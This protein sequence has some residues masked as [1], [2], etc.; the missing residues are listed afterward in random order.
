MFRHIWEQA[1]PI[2]RQQRF[3]YALGVVFAL[4]TVIHGVVAVVSLIDGQSWAGPVSWRKP[5][6]FAASFALLMVAMA[7][8]LRHLPERRWG[9]IPTVLSLI[10]I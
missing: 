2:T 6:V 1:R 4:S 8:V 3:F 5:V 10:H 9:W 7:W